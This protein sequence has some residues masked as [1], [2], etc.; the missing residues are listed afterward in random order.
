LIDLGISC[1]IYENERT[2]YLIYEHEYALFIQDEKL[3][4]KRTNF[5]LHYI[6]SVFL[7]ENLTQE[8]KVSSIIGI[9]KP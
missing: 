7:L 5:Y 1:N 9:K 3:N 2:S 4:S 8:Q 6:V